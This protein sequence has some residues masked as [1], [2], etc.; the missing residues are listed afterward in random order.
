MLEQ[1]GAINSLATFIDTALAQG[2]WVEITPKFYLEVICEIEAIKN[3]GFQ[4]LPTAPPN[5]RGR[6]TE[7]Q[8]RGLGVIIKRDK[9]SLQQFKIQKSGVVYTMMACVGA[10]SLNGTYYLRPMTS[11]DYTTKQ[12]SRVSKR[13]QLYR[14]V[15]GVM[16]M[17]SCGLGLMLLANVKF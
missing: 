2:V 9:D 13:R 16:T 1:K 11:R 10:K 3:D 14:F 7:L 6:M 8:D 15:G 17:A 5:L 4:S 12:T